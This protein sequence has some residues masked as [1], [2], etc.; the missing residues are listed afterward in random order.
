M[1]RPSKRYDL[2]GVGSMVVDNL[3]RVPHM[4][5]PDQKVLLCA[6][7]GEEAVQRRV[8][9]VVLNHL[10]W[11]RILGLRVAVFGKQADDENGR[12]LRSGMARLGIEAHLDLSGSASS[13][14][15]V[16]ITPN[17]ERAIYMA[18]GATGE[19]SAAEMETQHREVI[20]QAH[21]VTSEVSQVPLSAV[22]R[23]LELAHEAGAKTVLDLDVPKSDA[24][25]GLG[26]E[27]ELLTLLGLADLIKSSLGA[28]D[29]I[30]ETRDPEAAAAEL[31]RRFG[32][33]TIAL[34]LGSEGAVVYAA[35][36]ADRVSAPRVRVVDTTGAGDAFLGG[37]LAGLQ[38]GLD[39]SSAAQLGNAAG[40]TCCERA[41]AFPDPIEVCRMRVLELYRASGGAPYAAKRPQKAEAL[42]QFLN[43]AALEVR[44]VC[45]A[46]DQ[47]QIRAAA[48]LILEA[49]GCG[50]RVHI[51]GVGKP[52]HLARY[53]AALFASTGTPAT[54]LHGTEATHGSVG[55]VHDKDVVIAISNSGETAELLDCVEVV[56]GFGVRVIAVTAEPDSPLG[57]AAD[58]VLQARVEQEGGPIGLAPRASVLAQ[59]VM[60]AALS[61]ELEASKGFGQKDFHRRHPGGR[62]GRVTKGA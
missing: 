23:A 49:E 29:G 8:G 15:Q 43:V 36:K 62:L 50:G 59:F 9:G 4:L 57:R 34:T 44:R 12:F 16:Y 56:R 13:F 53:A 5:E 31:A 19:L 10:A 60:L 61:V 26:S 33:K 52:E 45:S 27:E 51:T 11:A 2:A 18:R 54:F 14:A 7:P 24:V 47:R 28:L 42:E 6:E 3:H 22:R 21:W 37:F 46:A 40:A 58:V 30:V 32:A 1:S 35:E 38:A 39:P 25:P 41:G 20:G 48:Q 55:Q 17:G